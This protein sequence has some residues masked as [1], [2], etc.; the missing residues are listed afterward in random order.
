MKCPKCQAEM[1]G[2]Q[3]AAVEVDRCGNCGGIWFDMLEQMDLKGARGAAAVD[4]GDAA[5]G[6]EMDKIRRADC[7]RC[8]AGMISLHVPDQPH[9]VVEQ[10]AICNGVFMDAGEFRDFS[11]VTPIEFL[12]SLFI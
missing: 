11:Q 7:P 2:I 8:H 10:C 9:I 1:A 6:K 3:F 4:T 5:K 12:R